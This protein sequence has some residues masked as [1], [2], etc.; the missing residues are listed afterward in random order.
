MMGEIEKKIQK[1]III[2]K[3]FLPEHKRTW[4]K[5]LQEIKTLLPILTN[6][7]EE[8]IHV[9]S[10]NSSND[11]YLRQIQS[12]LIVFI[13]EE[14]NRTLCQLKDK[15][16]NLKR[17]DNEAKNKIDKLEEST[18]WLDCTSK[19]KVICGSTI[20]PPLKEL[21]MY[22]DIYRTT[23]IEHSENI[24]HLFSNLDVKNRESVQAF[25]RYFEANLIASDDISFLLQMLNNM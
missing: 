19:S 18:T 12:E 9:E 10:V 22:C 5:L 7:S 14:I 16:T 11:D 15:I 20:Q 25:K 24:F 13:G 6:Q 17:V 23:F 1:N 4:E 3:E 8:I 21:L 2:L